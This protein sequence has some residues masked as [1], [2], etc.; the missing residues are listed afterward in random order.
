MIDD[1]SL[2]A[3]L[4]S[5]IST[6]LHMSLV[7]IL[8]RITRQKFVLSI[9]VAVFISL[10]IV[11]LSVM[12]HLIS[13]WHLI[14]F[15]SAG[16][17]LNLF[18]YGAVSKSLSLEMLIRLLANSDGKL[19]HIVI[20]R[21]VTMPAFQARVSLLVGKGWVSRE[22]DNYRISEEGRQTAELIISA[23]RFLKIQ[24]AGLYGDK[25]SGSSTGHE[26]G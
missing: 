4:V 1:P 19:D 20:D 18:L 22:D 26:G 9:M 24:N 6:L 25:A 7:G 10:V 8:L 23:R 15:S 21:Q 14:S 12:G 13:S 2:M 16:L 3:F 11:I 5:V 17:V